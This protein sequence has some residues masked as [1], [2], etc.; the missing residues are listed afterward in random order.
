MGKKSYFQNLKGTLGVV[1]RIILNWILKKWAV[2][3]WTGS[4]FSG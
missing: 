3:V 1:G 4:V 2:R